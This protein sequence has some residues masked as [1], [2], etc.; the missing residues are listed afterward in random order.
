MEPEYFDLRKKKVT[1]GDML[2]VAFRSGNTAELRVGTIIG[3]GSRKASYS[4]NPVPLIEIEW[5]PEIKGWGPEKSKIEAN[6]G[7][8]LI[9]S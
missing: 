4:T 5:D 7:R 6:N 3:F 2:A 9:I 8:Y 1:I